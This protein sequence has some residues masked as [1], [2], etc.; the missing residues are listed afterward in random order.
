MEYALGKFISDWWWSS[1]ITSIL[2]LFANSI[3]SKDIVPQSTVKINLIPKSL[4]FLNASIEG[5]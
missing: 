1:T 5:P 4:N 3:A 2:L